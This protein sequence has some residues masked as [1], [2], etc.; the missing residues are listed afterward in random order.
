MSQASVKW[1][2]VSQGRWIGKTD[3]RSITLYAG[4]NEDGS[5]YWSDGANNGHCG[6]P[7]TTYKDIT[8]PD[9]YIAAAINRCKAD[10]EAWFAKF[11]A[12]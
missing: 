10:A 2:Q 4:Q 7:I 5:F 3:N 9:A 12:A 8:N 6:E 1:E 11:M